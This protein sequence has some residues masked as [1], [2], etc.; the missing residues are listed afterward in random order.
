MPNFRN[1]IRSVLWAALAAAAFLL[2]Y[3]AVVPGGKTRYRT[4]F[5]DNSRFI[6]K[7][8]PAERVREG[9]AGLEIYGEPAYFSLSTPRGFDRAKLK[10]AFRDDSRSPVIEA[11]VLTDKKVWNYDLKPVSNRLI[12]K[13]ALEW[14]AVIA[15]DT[16]LLQKEKRYEDLDSFLADLP[17]MKKLSLYN[18]NINYDYRDERDFGEPSIIDVPLRGAMQFYI[19]LNNGDLDIDFSV[20][21]LNLNRDQDGLEVNV[22]KQD[23]LLSSARLEDDGIR[24][25]AGESLAARNLP[26]RIGNPG[27]G[28]Y[29]IE[30]KCNSDIVVERLAAARGALSFIHKLWISDSDRQDLS[31]YTDSRVVT[32]ET[33]NPAKLQTLDVGGKDLELDATFRQFGIRTE[34]ELS[35]IVLEKDDLIIAGDG[36]F[37]FDDRTLFNPTVQRLNENSDVAKDGT[38][39]ILARYSKPEEKDGWQV[40]EVD[41]DLSKAYRENGRYSFLIS[42]PRLGTPSNQGSIIVKSI[43]VELQG[44]DII[45]FIGSQWK[46][47][48]EKI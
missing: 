36:M 16:I 1:K 34:S 5:R 6:G 9:S 19:Y 43:E 35:R 31:L 22:Y 38:E 28:V 23:R 11:G 20:K 12:D 33:I 4:D 48:K 44:K 42:V 30:L 47:I 13:L 10:I 15:D 46:K 14:P 8:T 29:K 2:I 45:Q 21:D 39:Y 32:A 18:Y 27:E 3:L 37:S 26:V 7:L 41:F 40:A 17:D 24:S 25:D